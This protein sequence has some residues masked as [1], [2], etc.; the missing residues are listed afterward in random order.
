MIPYE[1]PDFLK[2]AFNCPYC[3]AYSHH[4]WS[5]VMVINIGE[6]GGNAIIGYAAY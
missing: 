1:E 3:N 5:K 4:I 6:T 2:D